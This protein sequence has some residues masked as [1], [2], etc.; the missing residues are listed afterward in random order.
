MPCRFRLDSQP[1][2]STKTVLRQSLHREA[3]D[4]VADGFLDEELVTGALWV[5]QD[6]IS[7]SQRRWRHFTIGTHIDPNLPGVLCAMTPW[8]WT[9]LLLK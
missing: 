2:L 8:T 9:Q 3:G 1:Q 4:Q 6:S 7:H 5:A